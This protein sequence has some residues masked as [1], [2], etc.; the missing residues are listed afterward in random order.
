LQQEELRRFARK[1]KM[2]ALTAMKF[3]S[4]EEKVKAQRDRNMDNEEHNVTMLNISIQ[5]EN[6]RMTGWLRRRGIPWRDFG[7][8]GTKNSLSRATWGKG[9]RMRWKRC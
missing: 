2:H 6:V 3:L 9:R 5:E 4:K 1:E 8:R 7:L